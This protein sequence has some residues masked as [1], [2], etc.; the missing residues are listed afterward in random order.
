MNNA[1][2]EIKNGQLVFRST[3]EA[4]PEDE[5][6][7]VLRGCDKTALGMLKIYQSSMRPVTDNWKG[8]QK[9][10]DD[11]TKFRQENRIRMKP[12]DEAYSS[13]QKGDE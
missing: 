6:V 10:M 2:F 1:K 11:F 8:V 5:P 3:G 9:V 13:E 4:I 7:F 12:P